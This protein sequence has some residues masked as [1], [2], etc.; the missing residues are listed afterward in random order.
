M[1]PALMRLI[2]ALAEEE[3]DRLVASIDETAA[4]S[5]DD[6]A[7]VERQIAGT[8]DACPSQGLDQ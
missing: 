4:A 6:G 8:V 2:H 5:A 1:H 7:P 3:A